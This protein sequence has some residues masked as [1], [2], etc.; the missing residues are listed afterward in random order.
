MLD[1]CLCRSRL[2]SHEESLVLFNTGISGEIPDLSNLQKLEV[3]KVENCAL[4]GDGFTSL[5]DIP[6]LKVLGLAGNEITGSLEGIGNLINLEEL[7][8]SHTSIGGTLPSGIGNLRQLKYIKGSETL[9]TG[10]IPI[11][12]TN[13][14]NLIELDLS[15]S[16]ISGGIPSNI[17]AL[18]SLTT[19]VLLG[20]N[21]TGKIL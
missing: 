11:S 19:L 20:N 5:F 6:S 8:I 7:Y 21:L 1:R 18:E 10:A 13:L 15:Q 3:F 2:S 9:L 17:G 16:S 12:F 14:K 4:T